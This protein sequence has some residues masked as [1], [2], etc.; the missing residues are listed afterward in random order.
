M[1]Q[2]GK[3]NQTK[4]LLLIYGS[5]TPPGRTASLLQYIEKEVNEHHSDVVAECVAPSQFESSSLFYWEES[6][7]EKVE[8]A[9]AVIVASP[10]Y[11]ASMPAILKQLFDELPVS[12]LRSKPVALITVGNVAEHYLGVERHFYDILSWFGSLYVPATC[13]FTAPALNEGINTSMKEE[14]HQLVESTLYLANKLQ[15]KK[16]GPMPLAE[17]YGR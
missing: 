13:Y 1:E 17:R 10:V 12:A 11:R 3:S 14:L 2:N 9:S 16:L 4:K 6:I 7:L 5:P 8:D 15:D